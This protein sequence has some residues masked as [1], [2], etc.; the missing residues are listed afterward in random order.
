MMSGNSCNRGLSLF[1]WT[2]A[3]GTPKPNLYEH[4]RSLAG[5][6]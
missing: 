5:I 2:E 1:D 3:N 4:I 6:T